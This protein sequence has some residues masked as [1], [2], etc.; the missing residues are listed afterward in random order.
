VKEKEKAAEQRLWDEV[1]ALQKRDKP[2]LKIEYVYSD[3]DSEEDSDEE[4]DE[5]LDKFQ[6]TDW[7]TCLT[8]SCFVVLLLVCNLL[9]LQF[10]FTMQV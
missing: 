7:T 2:R 4:N 6:D 1:K 8:L 9:V 5:D 3:E 10:I